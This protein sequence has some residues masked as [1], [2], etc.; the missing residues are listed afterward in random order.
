MWRFKCTH[1]QRCAG[2]FVFH[3]RTNNYGNIK[4]GQTPKCNLKIIK[5]LIKIKREKQW[6]SHLIRMEVNSR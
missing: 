5:I 3:Q 2:K 6:N 1:W 4:P